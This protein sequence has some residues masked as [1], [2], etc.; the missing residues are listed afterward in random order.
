LPYQSKYELS[1]K[2]ERL[3]ETEMAL[4]GSSNTSIDG[5]IG[6]LPSTIGTHSTG[7]DSSF[8]GDDVTDSMNFEVI[9]RQTY[10]KVRYPIGNLRRQADKPAS[11]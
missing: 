7:L 10:L 11:I 4:R 6:Y 3:L 8:T 9:L 2:D 5:T 1:G